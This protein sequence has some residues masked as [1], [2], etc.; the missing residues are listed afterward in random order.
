[1]KILLTNDDSYDSPLFHLLYDTLK[2]NNHEV[3]CVMPASEQSWKSKSMTRFGKLHSLEV[4]VDG[5]TFHT[6]EGTPADDMLRIS[7]R[8]FLNHPW[9]QHDQE[10][11]VPQWRVTSPAS[12]LFLYHSNCL[13]NSTDTGMKPDPS[14]KKKQINWK[15][16]STALWKLLPCLCRTY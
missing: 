15:G 4:T 13:R 14:L 2:S 10:Q 5:R 1:M 16:S 12:L 11:L 8:A 3:Y 9:F 7:W 6:F